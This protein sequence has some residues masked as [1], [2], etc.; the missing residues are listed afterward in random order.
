MFTVDVHE[1]QISQALIRCRAL[2]AVSDQGLRYL[3][4]HMAGLCRG[5]HKLL[6]NPIFFFSFQYLTD[7]VIY[8]RSEPCL[9][10]RVS[11]GS[12]PG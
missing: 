6:F 10:G 1:R 9:Y 12:L 3:L 11:T 4:L 7:L 5:R 2:R 8:T